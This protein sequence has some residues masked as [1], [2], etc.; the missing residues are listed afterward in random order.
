MFKGIF[1]EI[2][3]LSYYYD[4]GFNI[5]KNSGNMGLPMMGSATDSML[6]TVFTQQFQGFVSPNNELNSLN[7]LAILEASTSRMGSGQMAMP[8]MGF[9]MPQGNSAMPQSSPLDALF[10]SFENLFSNMQLGGVRNSNAPATPQSNNVG[11]YSSANIDFSKF[12]YI[13]KKNISQINTLRPEMQVSVVELIRRAHAVGIDGIEVTSA[14]RDFK[15]QMKKFL[16]SKGDGSVA[17]PRTSQHVK[18]NAVDL[19]MNRKLNPKQ[20]AMLGKIW[21]DMGYTYGMDFRKF[22]ER[23]HFDGRPDIMENKGVASTWF[24]QH[25]KSVAWANLSGGSNN[26]LAVRSQYSP[27]INKVAKEYGINARL[28]SFVIHDES[29]G[30]KKAISKKGALGLGQLMPRTARAMGVKNPFDPE[31]NL[32]GSARYFKI[33]LNKYH[34][35]AKLTLAAYNWGPAKVDRAIAKAHSTDYNL[36]APHIFSGTQGYVSSILRKYHSAAI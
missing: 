6:N 33:L 25:G 17:D 32:R 26:G 16:A 12:P 29:T 24:A 3:K 9:P 34:G 5:G 18:R 4:I 28:F 14:Y 8:Q 15:T 30:D 10:K 21:K 35:D 31:D 27:L 19:N 36:V 2:F 23:W 22:R 20:Y 7:N 13:S 11:E 1:T